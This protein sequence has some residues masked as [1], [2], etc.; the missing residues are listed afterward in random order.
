MGSNHIRVKS[1]NQNVFHPILSE[2]RET[3]TTRYL[4][5]NELNWNFGTGNC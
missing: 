2:K 4:A 5:V 3:S 1:E